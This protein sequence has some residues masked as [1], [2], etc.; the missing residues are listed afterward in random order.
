[1]PAGG[2][3]NAGFPLF[4]MP[5]N[6]P[7]LQRSRQMRNETETNARTQPAGPAAPVA[8]AGELLFEIF[9]AVIFLGMIGLVFYNAFLRYVFSSSYPPSEEWARFL[10]IYITFFGAIEAFYRKKHIAVDMVVDM[11]SGTPRKVVDI[12]GILLA[13]GA[14]S[15]LLYGGVQYVLQTLD[16]YSVATSVNMSLIN[17]TLPIMALAALAMQA[18]DLIRL[19]RT[20]SSAFV[21]EDKTKHITDLEVM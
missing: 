10:F 15:L 1:M 21:K 2:A 17:G 3:G 20:P 14:M 4:R 18:R 8:S 16:T 19:I 13:M 6:E 9:C 12:C 11:L 5:V 7:I